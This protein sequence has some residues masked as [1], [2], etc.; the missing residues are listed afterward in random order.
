MKT[1]VLGDIHGRS[2][3]KDI[4]H[5]ENPD[6]IIFIGDYFD[7]YEKDNNAIQQMNNFNEII[8]LKKT[9]NKE[10]ILLIGNHDYHYMRG[11]AEHYSGYQPLHRINIE[12]LLF[13]NMI[14]LQMCYVMDNIFFTHAG[15][16]KTFLERNNIK[17]GSFSYI[18]NSLNDLIVYKPSSFAFCGYDIYGDDITQSPIWV[19][20]KSLLEDGIDNIIQIVGHT[21][22]RHIQITSVGNK[23]FYFIDA[24]SNNEYLTIIDNKINI[25]SL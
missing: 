25:V 17:I 6:R 12:E 11:V 1:V 21:Y 9:F 8:Q 16:T 22:V 19:R 7:S 14:Y 23:T 15:I 13:T 24:I 10:I 20:P 18:E 2:V 3:W 4:I 5:K